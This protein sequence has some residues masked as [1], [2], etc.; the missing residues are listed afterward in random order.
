MINIFKKNKLFK[1]SAITYGLNNICSSENNSNAPIGKIIGYEAAKK[2]LLPNVYYQFKFFILDDFFVGTT[3]GFD[4]RRYTFKYLEFGPGSL[5]VD[6]LNTIFDIILYKTRSDVTEYRYGNLYESDSFL[7]TL[8]V[9]LLTNVNIGLFFIKVLFLKFNFFDINI[10]N[11]FAL[12]RTQFG[13]FAEGLKSSNP[14]KFENLSKISRNTFLMSLLIPSINFDIMRLIDFI[15]YK[16]MTFTD[17]EPV[18]NNTEDI[19]Q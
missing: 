16:K 6:L 10:G 19:L 7:N 15:K 4:I 9:C 8:K 3:V 11:V 2:V 12:L 1:Y 14:D 13:A 18:N 5:R 17:E